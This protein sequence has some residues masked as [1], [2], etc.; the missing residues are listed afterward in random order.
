[1]ELNSDRSED[2]A[3]LIPDPVQLA[4]YAAHLGKYNLIDNWITTAE[5]M[6][7]FIGF[8]DPY[9]IDAISELGKQS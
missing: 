2:D 5:Q 6:D 7:S 1:M 9:I 4:L 3:L 8:C